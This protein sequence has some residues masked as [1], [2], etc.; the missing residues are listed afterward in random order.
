MFRTVTEM[1]SS[2]TDVDKTYTDEKII[3]AT[4]Y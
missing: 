4:I 1:F 3:I 2:L